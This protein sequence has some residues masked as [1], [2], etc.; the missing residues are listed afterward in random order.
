MQSAP[1][2]FDNHRGC[3]LDHIRRMAA[4]ASGII[5]MICKTLHSLLGCQPAPLR[6]QQLLECDDEGADALVVAEGVLA[7]PKSLGFG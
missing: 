3:G 1:R 4:E 7:G 6:F 2:R 5:L